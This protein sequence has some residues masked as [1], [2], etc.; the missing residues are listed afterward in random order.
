M[1]TTNVACPNCGEDTRGTLPEKGAKI[2]GVSRNIS[3]YNFTT[4]CSNCGF[5]FS[6]G[7]E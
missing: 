7:A 2:T 6:I 5:K 1:P 4:S 3:T